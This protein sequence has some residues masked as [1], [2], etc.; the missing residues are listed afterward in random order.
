LVRADDRLAGRSIAEAVH[1]AAAWAAAAQ[2]IEQ[3]VPR[4]HPL[5]CAD[6]LSVVGG[7]FLDWASSGDDRQVSLREWRTLVERIHEVA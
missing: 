2:G 7:D 3:R 4:L 6:Q 5:A 1:Q